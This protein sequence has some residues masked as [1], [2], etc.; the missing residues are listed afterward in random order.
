MIMVMAVMFLQIYLHENRMR[1]PLLV[2]DDSKDA[3]IL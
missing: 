1:N 2:I 3:V